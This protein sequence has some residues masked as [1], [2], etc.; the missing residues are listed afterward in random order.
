MLD[1]AT[2]GSAPSTTPEVLAPSQRRTFFY[3]DCETQSELSINSK[4]DNYVTIRQFVAHPSTRVRKYAYAVDDGPV[5]IWYPDREPVPPEFFEAA[6]N[7]DWITVGHNIAEFDNLLDKYV[8]KILTAP[9]NRTCDTMPMLGRLGLPRGLDNGCEIVGIPIRKDPAATKLMKEMARPFKPK[10]DK[11]T[12]E[13]ITDWTPEQH[14]LDDEY[15]KNDVEMTRALFKKIRPNRTTILE[16]AIWRHH[17]EVVDRGMPM[18]AKLVDK[19]VV[20]VDAIEAE[21]IAGLIEIS[22]G[23]IDG[24]GQHDR[25]KKFLAAQGVETP[26]LQ[27]TDVDRLLAQANLPEKARRLLELRKAG[28]HAAPKKWR[29]AKRLMGEGNRI[30]G[31]AFYHGASTGRVTAKG[32]QPQNAKN[33][34]EVKGEEI[35]KAIDLVMN[36]SYADIKAA[37]KYPLEM[38]GDLVRSAIRAPEDFVFAEADYSAIEAVLAAWFAG[39]EA[40]QD[41]V[42]YFKTR[43]P[44]DDP[45]CL[46]YCRMMGLPPGSINKKDHPKE[47]R[48]GKIAVLAFCYGGKIPAWRK[49]DLDGDLT[50]E[51]VLKINDAF[52]RSRPGLRNLA[53]Q[54]ESTPLVALN[55]P[56]IRVQCGK[57]AF[58]YNKQIDILFMELPSSRRISYPQPQIVEDSY[59]GLQIEAYHWGEKGQWQSRRIWWGTF[60]DNMC[61]G[62]ARDILFEAM[63]RLE[64][65]NFPV[66]LHVHDQVLCEIP[67]AGAVARFVE[68]CRILEEPP[69][70]APDIPLMVEGR[71]CERF[72]KVEWVPE[73][74]PPEP[75]PAAAAPVEDGG[76]NPAEPEPVAAEPEPP[77]ELSLDDVELDE[78]PAATS[79]AGDNFYAIKGQVDLRQL[80]GATMICCPHHEERTPS[81]KIYADG[82]KCWG[83]GCGKAGDH[84]DY[85]MQVE[86]CD[87]DEARAI[88]E[89]FIADNGSYQAK[90]EQDDQRTRAQALTLWAQSTPITGTLA[91][92]YFVQRGVPLNWFKNDGEVLRFHPACSFESD[93]T[94]PA[95]VMLRRDVATGV[96]IGIHRL[97]LRPD[98]NAVTRPDGKK[99]RKMLGKWKPSAAVML[100]PVGSTLVIGEGLETVISAFTNKAVTE[101]YWKWAWSI[102]DTAGMDRFAPIPGVD[103]LVILVD[104]DP[105]GGGERAARACAALWRAAGKRVTMIMPVTVGT[106]FD[107]LRRTSAAYIVLTELKEEDSLGEI[108]AGILL[109]TMPEPRRWLAKGLFCR[110]VFSSLVGSGSI[111]KT[112]VRFAQLIKLATGSDKILPSQVIYGRRRVLLLCLEDDIKE[113]HRRLRAAC[114]YHGIDTEELVGWLFVKAIRGK[115]LVTTD[116]KGNRILGPLEKLLRDAI[117]RQN[118]DLVC[119]DPLIKTHT[120]EENSADM[121]FVADTL[122]TLAIECD[123]AVDSPHHVPKGQRS[124]GDPD[125]ARG[126]SSLRDAGRLFYTLVVMS[127]EEAA[128]LGVKEED[129][130]SYIRMDSSKVN[131]TKAS[132]R[133]QWF[134]LIGVEI[135]NGT[136]EY[137]AGDEVQ[138]VREWTPPEAT[139]LTDTAIDQILD[140]IATGIPTP[141][142]SENRYTQSLQAKADRHAW[143]VVMRFAPGL[144]EKKCKQAITQWIKTGVLYAKDYWDAKRN[145]VSGLYVDAAKRPAR[146]AS[147]DDT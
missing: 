75:P 97:A 110:G 141:D 45:Y 33:P 50:D 138:T 65:A 133:A 135:G 56:G 63:L 62:T 73:E 128:E 121:D 104:N 145:N 114:V 122:C 77:P 101:A 93:G 71:L 111:G 131:I 46:A 32:F 127:P 96:P 70:W 64:A 15:A 85:L 34:E 106:D 72:D 117:K 86:G 87:R 36:S 109:R 4:D 98:G 17:V 146:K 57:V 49:F 40:L 5:K 125:A 20:L 116:N 132:K 76:S 136:A 144:A 107:D 3:K 67:K 13:L 29:T 112:A 52:M 130:R 41:F 47:R 18:D 82:Y 120:L 94:H 147:D 11:K 79:S 19:M 8:L 118:I 66:T 124:P 126:H 31:W 100:A 80:V 12:K 139:A 59:Y 35:R 74:D 105:K 44:K 119:L 140:E 129:R 26:T 39:D 95:L 113:V 78:K 10:K 137:R 16:P 53:K 99:L 92:Q 115:K 83:A 84:F 28:N 91:E 123:I 55:N 51:E 2:N 90:Q 89:R 6:T 30:R 103:H 9:L 21:L 54:L 143:R 24:M 48:I 68:F 60:V 58:E 22:G 27:G 134:E 14:A 102:A 37:H 69:V 108:D 43:D 38:C 7:P 142:G 61:Q 88:L 1:P 25:M 81:C 23:A 42:N